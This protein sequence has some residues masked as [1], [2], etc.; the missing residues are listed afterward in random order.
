[1][2]SLYG[3]KTFLLSDFGFLILE[4]H[5]TIFTLSFTR[6]LLTVTHSAGVG[7]LAGL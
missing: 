3:F 7:S 6:I 1:M 4:S 2:L 5:Q